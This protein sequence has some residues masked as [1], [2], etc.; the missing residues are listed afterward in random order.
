MRIIEL[1]AN[2]IELKGRFIKTAQI[3]REWDVD[4]DDPEAIVRAIADSGIRADLF[5]FAQRLPHTKPRFP[6]HMEMDNV[7][8]IPISTYEEWWEN[9]VNRRVRLKVRKSVREG[10]R[11]EKVEYDD[12]FV[13]GIM[14]I[15]NESPVRQGRAFRHFGKSF[16]ET[17][18]ANGTYLD[19]AD[20]FGAYYGEELIGFLKIVYGKEFARTMGIMGKIAHR[21]KAPMNALIAKAVETCVGKGVPY[22]TYGRYFYGHK[23]ADSFSDF[24]RYNGF[25]KYDLPRYYVPLSALGRIALMLNLHKG[26]KA[27]LPGWLIKPLL[28]L[29]KG[30]VEKLHGD[31]SKSGQENP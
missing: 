5:T 9:Q 15:Y 22:L 12:D 28:R 18:E 1:G 20:I 14:R 7:A 11:I 2:T 24:K 10:V 25:L 31:R 4:V 8:A 21:D 27:A 17:K 6:Y 3:W 19:R 13:R 16:E 30:A 29:R 26:L 23:G